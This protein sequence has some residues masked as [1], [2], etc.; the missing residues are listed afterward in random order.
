MKRIATIA[1]LMAVAMIVAVSGTAGAQPAEGAQVD[2]VP[3]QDTPVDDAPQVV[4][5]PPADVPPEGEQA[6]PISEPGIPPIPGPGPSP[7]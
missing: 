5:N 2:G 6:P 3:P 4:V 7:T 1:V